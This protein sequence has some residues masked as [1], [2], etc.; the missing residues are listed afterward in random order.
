MT[1]MRKLVTL[2]MA[3]LMLLP[4]TAAF[5]EETPDPFMKFDH[6]VEV[7]IGQMAY[8][9]QAFPDG[10]TNE[11]NVF[12]RYLLENFNIKVVVDWSAAVG[13]DYNQKVN[14]CIASNTLPDGLQCD[15]KA[16]L[17]AANADMLY[18]LTEI[19]DQYAS[20]QVKEIM[21]AGGGMAF[22]YSK[23]NGKL[24]TDRRFPQRTCLRRFFS[25]SCFG[26]M[27]CTAWG[28]P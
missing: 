4:S 21:S 11:D 16:M 15:R 9:T 2:L 18:D 27:R 13:D 28:S 14:L 6:V 10:D 22:E 5:A 24:R 20:P 7:H 3:A 23:V 26:G 19:F 1:K 25:R 12:T 17:A 8:P